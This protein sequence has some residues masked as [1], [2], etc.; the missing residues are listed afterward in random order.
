VTKRR[1]NSKALNAGFDRL[2]DAALGEHD[3]P[4]GTTFIADDS[5]YSDL[6]VAARAMTGGAVALVSHDGTTQLFAADARLDVEADTVTAGVVS[7]FRVTSSSG[8][9]VRTLHPVID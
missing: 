5:P 1:P 9:F 4:P 8:G 7:R 6:L 2:V 3:Y